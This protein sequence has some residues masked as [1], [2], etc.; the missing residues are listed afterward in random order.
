MN[1]VDTYIPFRCPRAGVA[2][3]ATRCRGV[4][5]WSGPLFTVCGSA[6]FDTILA[7]KVYVALLKATYFR[8]N[9]HILID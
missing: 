2:I 8:N 6:H 7:I 5:D 4:Q 9:L 1:H 3:W